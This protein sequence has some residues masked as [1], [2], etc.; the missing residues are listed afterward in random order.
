MPIT[1][2][3]NRP[4]SNIPVG[5]LKGKAILQDEK[6]IASTPSHDIQMNS[7]YMMRDGSPIHMP[8]FKL[9]LREIKDPAAKLSLI[10]I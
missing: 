6:K 9:K 2:N 5:D 4:V 1:N 10:H 7:D 8:D 3:T